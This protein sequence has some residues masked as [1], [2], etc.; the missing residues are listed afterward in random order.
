MTQQAVQEWLRG[1]LEDIKLSQAESL[2]L[3]EMLP[4]LAED[5]IA[6]VGV[7]H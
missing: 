2:Q 1:T 4:Q 6:G 5:E 3:R 7:T